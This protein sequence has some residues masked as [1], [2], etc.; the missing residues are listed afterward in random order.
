MQP[1]GPLMTEHRLIERI[2]SSIDKEIKIIEKSGIINQSFIAVA[3]DFIQIYA[4]RTH[5]GKE[6]EILFRDLSKK[7]L[8]DNDNIIMNE[9]IQ[10]HIVGR[11][12]TANLVKSAAAY[13]NGDKSALPLITQSLQKFV[14][15]YPKHIEKEDKVFFPAS[16]KYFS[17]SEQQSM[18]NE[19]WEFDRE[20]IHVKYK[21]VIESLE[22]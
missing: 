22:K 14:D 11:N 16:M 20:M 15:F 6:E 13:Q 21:S 12:T 4:D 3:V 17:D 10:E 2:I 7:T 9:L 18:L 1:R 8:S 5:H 19:F